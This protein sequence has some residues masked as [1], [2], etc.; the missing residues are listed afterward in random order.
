MLEKCYNISDQSNDFFSMKLFGNEMKGV[1]I[2]TNGNAM[3]IKETESKIR[4]IDILKLLDGEPMRVKQFEN[5]YYTCLVDTHG[6]I[7]DKPI[8]LH[9]Y[10]VTGIELYG[11]VLFIKKE[12]GKAKWK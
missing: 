2:E 6:F 10:I 11:T 8:N 1:V 9:A 3:L 5:R 7:K 4:T 12:R